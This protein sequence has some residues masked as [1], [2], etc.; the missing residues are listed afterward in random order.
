LSNPPEGIADLGRGFSSRKGV[1]DPTAFLAGIHEP[2]LMQDRKVLGNRR[3]RQ[4]EKLHQMAHTDLPFAEDHQEPNP[5]WVSERPGKAH[6]LT[7]RHIL[8]FATERN[9]DS[10]V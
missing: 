7:K 1:V 9:I 8:Y 5:I 6:E 10:S 4:A 2:G 3:G